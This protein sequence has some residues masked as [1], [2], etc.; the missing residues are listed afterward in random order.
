MLNLYYSVYNY[1]FQQTPE[2][3]S[4]VYVCAC[5]QAPLAFHV[6]FQGCYFSIGHGI[7]E[8]FL[9]RYSTILSLD[10]GKKDKEIKK[11]F[12]LVYLY[13]RTQ[14]ICY[15]YSIILLKVYVI[16]GDLFVNVSQKSGSGLVRKWGFSLWTLSTLLTAM[17]QEGHQSASFGT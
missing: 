15:Q 12:S 16:R 9:N 13:V 14:N 7:A 11:G 10:P 5:K 4:T 3:L 6:Y 2:K 17:Q 1:S 8:P